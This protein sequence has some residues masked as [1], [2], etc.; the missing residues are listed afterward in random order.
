MPA[1]IFQADINKFDANTTRYDGEN[2]L[3]LADC[4]KLVYKPEEEIKAA[5]V[6]DWKFKNFKFFSG[7]STQAFVAGNGS[8]IIVAFRGTEIFKFADIKSDVKVGFAD[9]GIV[10]I[11]GKVHFGFKDALHEVWGDMLVTL[12]KYQDNKQS[13]WFCGHSLGGALATLAVAEYIGNAKGSINGLYTI[14][15]P[16]VGDSKFAEHF[17]GAV[18][19]KCFR[20]ANNNDAVPQLPLWSLMLKY[21]HIGNLIYIDSAGKFNDSISWMKLIWDRVRGVSDEIGELGFDHLKD[22]SNEKYVN[23]IDKNRSVT[24]K[25]S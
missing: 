13:V 18:E 7:E 2:A 8:I 25:W 16:R 24:T 4:A 6:G 15:Q 21:T 22:H 20:F 9:T 12:K 19:G 23:L 11:P 10:A 1:Y 5:I 3:V 14:G 17:D